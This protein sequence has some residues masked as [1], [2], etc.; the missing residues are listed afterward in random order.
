VAV[1]MLFADI[2]SEKELEHRLQESLVR[3]GYLFD[4]APC[5]ITVQDRNFR[6]IES[7]LRFSESFGECIGR[8]CYEAYKHRQEPCPRCPVAETFADRAIHTSEEVVVDN[9]GR[10]QHVLVYAAPLHDRDGS[11]ASVMEMS[12]D[13]TEVRASRNRLTDLGELVAGTAH[14]IKNILEGLR[15]GVYIVNLGFRN[16]N[17]ADARTGW[18]MV[19]RN[20]GRLS[21][22]IMDMLSYARDRVPSQL[23]VALH[24]VVSD[25]VAL[26]S[27]RAAQFGILIDSHVDAPVEVLGESKDLHAMVASLLTNAIDACNEDKAEKEHVI[28]VRLR[29]GDGTAIVEVEDN[30]AGMTPET[31]NGLFHGLISTK[32]SAGTGLGL[33]VAQK[34][35]RE[36][37]GRIEVR[38]EP[39]GGSLF[40]VTLPLAPEKRCEAEKDTHRG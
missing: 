32:G 13:V 11:I 10:Q 8:Y 12:T 25:A 39:G 16:R 37:G 1:M 14:T 28:Q 18:E 35:A 5:R 26:F 29:R 2:S 23:P 17:E 38:S 40:A 21:A 31:R 19:E 9:F 3:Y 20:L 30:G 6:I 27:T 15:G 36:H 7:N 33:L 24:T 4:H 34:A 22:A